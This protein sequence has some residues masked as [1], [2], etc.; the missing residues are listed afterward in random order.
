MNTVRIYEYEKCMYYK[1]PAQI[2][3]QIEFCFEKYKKNQIH[4]YFIESKKIFEY[5]INN[6]V[7]W[8]DKI[9]CIK[10]TANSLWTGQFGL[11]VGVWPSN[12]TNAEWP[13][14]QFDYTL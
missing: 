11:W 13:P 9:T 1:S 14:S 7:Y 8:F 3:I 12:R 6:T 5:Y 10:S 4:N 2:V